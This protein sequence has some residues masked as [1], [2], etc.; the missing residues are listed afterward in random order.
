MMAALLALS[1]MAAGQTGPFQGGWT[2]QSGA[3]AL[4]F[5]SVKNVTKVESSG[6]ATFSGTLD[7][8][9]GLRIAVLL[10]SI[11]T[12]VDL[13]NVRM[14]FLMFETFQFPEAVITA[15]IDPAVLADLPQIRRK[16]IPLSY[17]LTMHGVS[18]TFD[19]VVTAT[20]LTDDLVAVSSGTPISVA[21]DDFG[22]TGGVKKLEEA[23]NVTIIPSATVSFDF[24]FARNVEGAAPVVASV[25]PAPVALEAVGNF[26]LEACKGR[27]EILSRANSIFFATGS[28]TVDPQSVPFLDQ[29]VDIVSRCPGMTIEVSGHTDSVGRKSWNQ[30]L[31]EQRAAAVTA[32]LVGK[33]ID[34][35]RVVAVGFGPDRPVFPNDTAENKARNRRIEFAVVNG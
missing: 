16:Q 25:D 19:T 17:N 10:D 26:D 29:L 11:D 21:A 8:S 34:K 20:L 18:K 1:Q 12:K 28:A 30:T 31:S 14:R 35:S 33:G 7:E 13:R 9:G 23:A 5:Q 3:S 2:L 24:M 22:M 6:F 15:Q 32:H 27:F 4:N